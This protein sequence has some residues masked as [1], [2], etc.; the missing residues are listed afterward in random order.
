MWST[1]FG[2][3]WDYIW[4]YDIN[5]EYFSANQVLAKGYWDMSVA[6]GYNSVA[7]VNLLAPILSL[8][9]NINIIPLFKVIYPLIFSL[10]P[11]ILL[12]A[13]ERLLGRKVWAEFSILFF[14]FLFTF[15]TEMMALA[16]QMIAEVYLAFL[17]YATLKKMN[18]ILLT[19]FLVSLAISHYA[20]AYLTMFALL[21]L[22]FLSIT[23][24]EKKVNNV[25]I[26]LFSILTLFWYQNTGGGIEFHNLVNIGYETLLMMSDILNP[27]FSQGLGIIMGGTTFTR[28][29]A[30][31]INLIAQGLITMGILT[32]F[33]RI[34]L[35]HEQTKEH[36]EFYVISLAFFAYDVA[37]IVLPLF[38]NRLNATR[39]YQLTLFFLSPY[40]IIGAVATI[41]FLHGRLKRFLKVNE[42]RSD[43][44]IKIIA[45]FL[46]VYFLFN[47][48]FVL[49]VA[50]DPQPPQWLD[51]IHSPS[52]SIQEVLGAKWIAHHKQSD[53]IIYL[54]ESKFPLFLGFGINTISFGKEPEVEGIKDYKSLIYLGKDTIF[55]GEIQ[56]VYSD[57]GGVPKSV[58]L[59]IRET[60]L[61]K[62]LLNSN[63]V[64]SNN[65]V[66]VYNK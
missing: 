39:L 29:L 50:Q 65:Q 19:L 22:L 36:L 25:N 45:V 43:S 7:S 63:I 61:W 17:V 27:Q 31:W 55:K 46:L 13:Y 5:V 33:Y 42:L 6:A 23:K 58:F 12:K 49:V 15:F 51:K 18:P 34:L 56:S 62:Q 26:A 37:G 9:L 47:S 28:E 54:G 4:G 60:K 24:Q 11:V 20:T 21:P 59:K 1:V 35:K 38:A 8:V 41:K 64:Y 44:I 32:I 57:V 40:F 16:R 48:G 52:W 53:S 30:K 14:I 66:L 2:L 10:V 3:S